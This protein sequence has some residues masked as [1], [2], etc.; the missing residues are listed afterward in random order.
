[1]EAVE[2][3]GNF[4]REQEEF[5]DSIEGEDPRRAVKPSEENAS[6]DELISEQV[7]S[8]LRDKAEEHNEEHGDEEGKR[9]TYRMLKNVFNRGM[10]A[11]QD[12]HR[13]GMSPQQWSYARVNAFLYLVRNGNPENDAYNQDNDLLPEEHPKY[14]E[15]ASD[16]S[17]SEE[18]ALTTTDVIVSDVF[19]QHDPMGSDDEETPQSI[20][21]RVVAAELEP[22]ADE[23]DEVYDAWS[24][25]VNMTASEL[26]RWSKNPCSR[27]ASLEPVSVMK[28]NLRLLERNKSDWTENDISDAKRTVSFIAR[29]R[30]ADSADLDGGPYGCPSKRDISLLNWAFNPFG[31]MPNHPDTDELDSVKE[32]TLA[33]DEGETHS[34][35]TSDVASLAD[36]E[37]HEVSYEGSHD[38]DWNRPNLEDF[39]AAMGIED[40]VSEYDDLT[41]Q[42]QEDVASAFVIS[43]SGFPAE[44]YEDLKLPVVEPNGELSLNALAAVKGGRGA[45]QVEDLSDEMEEEIIDYVNQLASEEFDRNWSEEEAMPKHYGDTDDDEYMGSVPD[46]HM[47]E[48]REDAEEK[49][50]SMGIE[51]SHM[52]DGMYVPGDT[53]EMYAMAKEEMSQSDSVMVALPVKTDT[54]DIKMTN[55]SNLE[56]QLSQL[57]N[58]VAV[59]VEELEALESKADRFDEMSENLEALRERTEVLDEVDQSALEELRETESPTVVEQESYEELQSEAEQVKGVYATSLA[60]EMGAFDSEELAERFSIEELREKFEDEI[61]SVEEQLGATGSEEAQPRSQD[62]SEEELEQAH[63]ESEEELSD[64]V[65]AKQEEIRQKILSN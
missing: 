5:A 43:A 9:I 40:D 59:D 42:A 60:D 35:D 46:S 2:P 56:E 61:G 54:K 17:D 21:E 16:D 7:K 4:P 32:V 28:R 48:S 18:N 14:N 55:M 37:M 58:P 65:A 64:E 45:S 49:A 3:W 57:D 50:E 1:M 36:Y 31:S 26:R 19:G 38:N 53:H 39:V 47:F 12:S 15:D 34:G 52:M 62:P 24:D 63:G 51:G 20:V 29:M 33:A 10:G 27:E 8:A 22:D 6:T 30:G 41:Q 11:Y 25:S 44:N 13:E 23:L